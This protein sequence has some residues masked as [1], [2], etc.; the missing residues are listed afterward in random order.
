MCGTI[1]KGVPDPTSGWG[2]SIMANIAKGKAIIIACC[3]I[4]ENY[5]PLA[6]ITAMEMDVIPLDCHTV[7]PISLAQNKKIADILIPLT[8]RGLPAWRTFPYHGLPEQ[9]LSAFCMP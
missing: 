8:I 6:S 2:L 7:K 4:W 1:R 3:T 5:Y 9:T